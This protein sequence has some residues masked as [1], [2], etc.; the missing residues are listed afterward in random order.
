MFYYFSKG[1]LRKINPFR[2]AKYSMFYMKY[3]NK[4][5]FSGR[6]EKPEKIDVN[7]KLDEKEKIETKSKLEKTRK[8]EILLY[9]MNDKYSVKPDK[10]FRIN[11]TTIE[12]LEEST[13]KVAAKRVIKYGKCGN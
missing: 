1:N 5:N 11:F 12:S 10:E 9:I 2:N 4:H 6:I 7:I 13:K 8:E 3:T